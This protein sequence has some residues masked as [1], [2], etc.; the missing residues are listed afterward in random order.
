MMKRWLTLSA[1]IVCLSCLAV[2]GLSC[3]G[4][5]KVAVGTFFSIVLPETWFVHPAGTDDLDAVVW[6]HNA[7][8]GAFVRVIPVPGVKLTPLGVARVLMPELQKGRYGFRSDQLPADDRGQDVAIEYCND[9]DGDSGYLAVS[10]VRGDPE[11]IAVFV[12]VAY[13]RC[14]PQ[15]ARDLKNITRSARVIKK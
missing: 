2:G 7:E 5:H 9:L 15:L 11:L 4:G 6:L 12:G 1:V 3:L 10:R 8:Y 14:G 13:I